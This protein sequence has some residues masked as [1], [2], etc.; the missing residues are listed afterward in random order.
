[1]RGSLLQGVVDSCVF[2]HQSVER[3]SLRFYEEL[4]RHNYVTPTSYLE[5]LT[6][7]AKLLD[8]KR[9]EIDGKR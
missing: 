6:T 3:M 7:F 2:I 8:E 1:M 5:L 9:S 4:R